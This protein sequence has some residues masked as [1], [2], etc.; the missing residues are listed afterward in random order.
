MGSSPA[1]LRPPSPPGDH[2]RGFVRQLEQRPW[3]VQLSAS[4]EAGMRRSEFFTRQGRTRGWMN[5]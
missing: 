5:P 4:T 3:S 1:S 2:Q